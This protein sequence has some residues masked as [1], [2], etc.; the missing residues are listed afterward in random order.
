MPPPP[1]TFSTHFVGPVESYMTQAILV[2]LFCCLPLG[3]AAI[4]QA[5]AVDK[6]V[7]AGDMLK[8]QSASN[9]AKNMVIAGFVGGLLIIVVSVIGNMSSSRL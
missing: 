6:A 2:T 4:F 5:R 8:A 9:S 1:P 3:I 7:A